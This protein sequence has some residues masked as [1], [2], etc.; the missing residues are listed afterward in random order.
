[1]SPTDLSLPFLDVGGWRGKS[2]CSP[3]GAV[4]STSPSSLSTTPGMFLVLSLHHHRR[5]AHA[6]P[7]MPVRHKAR[8]QLP[9]G[10]RT[11][12]FSFSSPFPHP[13]PLTPT[14]IPHP[15]HN[16]SDS[17]CGRSASYLL[18]PHRMQNEKSGWQHR[19]RLACA[20]FGP[21]KC[22]SSQG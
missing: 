1:M 22:P 9:V 2:S 18:P 20:G 11:A 16:T 6:R 5:K 17:P 3:W 19:S 21:R 4:V 13:P 7:G 10:S 12:A 8:A 14:S 15:H